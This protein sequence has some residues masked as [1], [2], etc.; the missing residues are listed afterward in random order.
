MCS[1]SSGGGGSGG[2]RRKPNHQPKAVQRGCVAMVGLLFVLSLWSGSGVFNRML[3]E[4]RREHAW[5]DVLRS[6]CVGLG[7]GHVYVCTPKHML[8]HKVRGREQPSRASR[9]TCPV[10]S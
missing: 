6:V 7:S 4:V 1:T 5:N 2:V 10:D 3:R 8:H 9:T